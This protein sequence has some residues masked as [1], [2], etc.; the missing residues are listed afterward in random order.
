MEHSHP[1]H[2]W[3]LLGGLCKRCWEMAERVGAKKRKEMGS[4][5]TPCVGSAVFWLLR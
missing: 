3:V 1:Q 5:P 2:L 4:A